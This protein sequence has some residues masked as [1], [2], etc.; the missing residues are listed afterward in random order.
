MLFG[1]SRTENGFD[2]T[3]ACFCA[4]SAAKASAFAFSRSRFRASFCSSFAAY[5]ALK[6]RPLHARMLVEIGGKICDVVHASWL[7]LPS[8]F[9]LA[10]GPWT[11]PDIEGAIHGAVFERAPHLDKEFHWIGAQIAMR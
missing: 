5:L 1:R 11:S 8:V 9:A 10:A 2:F 3:A 4:A 7:N 6:R